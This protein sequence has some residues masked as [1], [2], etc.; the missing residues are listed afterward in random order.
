MPD[1]P[2]EAGNPVYSTVQTDTIC[3]G[4]DLAGYLS[5]EFGVPRPAWAAD[6]PRPIEFWDDMM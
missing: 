5:K 2:C 1:R 6:V 4:F 3:Y